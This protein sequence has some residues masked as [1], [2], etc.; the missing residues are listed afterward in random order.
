[1]SGAGVLLR[2]DE[3]A[4]EVPPSDAVGSLNDLHADGTATLPEVVTGAVGFAREFVAA[5]ATGLRAVDAT[6][7]GSLFTRT[8]SVQMIGRWDFDQQAAAATAGV[9]ICRGKRGSSSERIAYGVELRVVNAGA[10]IGE[11]RFF[12]EDLDGNRYTAF[13]GQFKLGRASETI[14]VTAVRRWSSTRDIVVRYFLG[15]RLLNESIVPRGD[16]GGGT[17]GTTTIG[18]RIDDGDEDWTDHFDGTIDEL[19][20]VGRELVADEIAATWDRIRTLQPLG[21]QLVLDC[22]PPGM[23]ISD[24]PESR[25]QR[26]HRLIG[27]G[28]GYAAA[29]FEN[30]RQN[31]MPDRAYGRTL[32]RWQ[33][34][35]RQSARPGDDADTRRRRVGGH[36]ARHAGVSPPGV[37]AA[38]HE[39]LAC[40]E[41]QLE[42]FAYDNTIR[43][44][45]DELVEARWRRSPEGE[46]SVAAGELAVA[47][48]GAEAA[49]FP[50]S[51][52][53]CMT[54]VDGPERIGGFGAQLFAKLSPTTIPDGAEVGIML[55][56]F[57][58][59]DGLLFG[60]RRDGADYKVV[61]QRYLAGVEQTAVVYATTA[62]VPHW[63]GLEAVQVEY[64][65]QARDDLVTHVVRWSTT[66]ATA[67]FTESDPEDLSDSPQ[68][69]FAV[70]WC[71]FY[72]RS[73][74]GAVLAGA[75][76]ASFD[77]AVFRFPNGLR[78]FQFYVLRDPDLPG[79]YDL[80]GANATLSKLRQSHTHAAAIT[81]PM[82]AGDPESG[83]GFGPCGG[84]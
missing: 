77:N 78:P 57:P 47:V 81:G 14:M 44:S 16:I 84:I 62:L 60:L 53:T 40:G 63:L 42:L 21:E 56:D 82:L 59:R 15:D 49:N 6:P 45:F 33:G 39:L 71:G 29:Q 25:V 13:G 55:F 74:N 50:S 19:R 67:G 48:A 80:R 37:R 4:T 1:M 72:A 36:L 79:E 46:W 54:G 31:V 65:G 73:W 66:S 64:D 8:V 22:L 76:A 70:G 68:F 51:W 10:R 61:S 23:P 28:L 20:V 58:R 7:G 5:S 43:D 27:Q 9:I 26:E 12:W 2:F 3:P 83:C 52:R 32:E 18:G 41:D 11:I 69:S 38:L 17:T 34:I 35:T 30:V 75:L 24:N